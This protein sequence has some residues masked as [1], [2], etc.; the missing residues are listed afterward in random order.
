[1]SKIDVSECDNFYQI[2]KNDNLKFCTIDHSKCDMNCEYA[3]VL[4]QLQQLKAENEE[5]KQKLERIKESIKGY[6]IESLHTIE[7][8]KIYKMCDEYL[9]L[10]KIKE[11]IESEN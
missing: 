5:L 6:C 4:K 7:K 9:I 2:G 1:M 11:M 3:K 10:C 8:H